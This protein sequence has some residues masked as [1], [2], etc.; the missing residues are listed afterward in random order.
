MKKFDTKDCEAEKLNPY[1]VIF[2]IQMLKP[3]TN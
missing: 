1:I 3:L 2:T